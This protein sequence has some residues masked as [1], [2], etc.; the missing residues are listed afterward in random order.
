MGALS[1]LNTMT[2]ARLSPNRWQLLTM[3][4]R[5]SDLCVPGAPTEMNPHHLHS[6]DPDYSQAC[7]KREFTLFRRAFNKGLAITITFTQV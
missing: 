2:Q 6:P 3:D 4:Q 7:E 1:V 5:D